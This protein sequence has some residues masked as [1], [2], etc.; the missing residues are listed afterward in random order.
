[1]DKYFHLNLRFFS[2]CF[3]VILTISIFPYLNTGSNNTYVFYTNFFVA[4]FLILLILNINNKKTK[5]QNNFS[6]IIVFL[7]YLYYLV[8]FSFEGSVL[9]ENEIYSYSFLDNKQLPSLAY[10]IYFPFILVILLFENIDRISSKS[11]AERLYPGILRF[12][13]MIILLVSPTLLFL[14]YGFDISLTAALAT[15]GL[16]TAIIG[17]ALQGNLSNVVSGIFLN[18]EKPFNPGDWVSVDGQLGQIK[19]ISWR[20]TSLTSI[21]NMHIAIPNDKLAKATVINYSRNN[22]NFSKGGFITYDSISVHPRHNPLYILDLMKDGLAKAKPVDKREFFGFTDVWFS[23]AN[24]S[25]L[26]FWIGYD[27]LDRALLFSQRSSVMLSINYVLTRAGITMVTGR[28]IQDLEPDASLSA[29]QDLS[30]NI[31]TFEKLYSPL[32]NIYLDSQKP[33][34][35]FRRVKVFE[36]LSNDDFDQLSSSVNRRQFKVGETIIKQGDKGESM[37][38]VTEGVVQVI[39]KDTKGKEIII[40]NLTI[41]EVFGEMTLLTGSK[42]SATVKAIRPVVLFEI[43]KEVFEKVLKAND[44]VITALSEILLIRENELKSLKNKNNESSVDGKLGFASLKA[45]TNAIRKFF[46]LN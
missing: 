23:G 31:E 10:K 7:G 45:I 26:K 15:S 17:L 25:G 37:F 18:F 38:L 29:I 3:L 24:D 20:T 34:F 27:C 6:L 21:E 13:L 8:F 40:D 30:Q 12:L 42:R 19:S 39:I 43:S 44:K 5:T 35:W 2:K 36:P 33:E 28:I 1:M 16:I 46:N 9:K 14:S 11:G 32:N 22:T 41:G 4:L